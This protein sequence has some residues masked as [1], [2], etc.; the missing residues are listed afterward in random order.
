MEL[1]RNRQVLARAVVRLCKDYEDVVSVR[2]A[3]RAGNTENE[4]AA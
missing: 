2:P 3:A 1:G 4:F